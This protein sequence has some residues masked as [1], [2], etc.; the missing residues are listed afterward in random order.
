MAGNKILIVEDETAIARM[1]WGQRYRD[2]GETRTVDVHIGQLRKRLGLSEH[3]KTVQSWDIVW[4]NRT[5]KIRTRIIWICCAAVLAS[6]L[7]GDAVLW[8][9]AGRSFQN[10]AFIEA[11]QNAYVFMEEFRQTL[12]EDEGF[13][14]S[15]VFLQYYFKT[16]G[17]DYNICI[18]S[19][20]DY[21]GKVSQPEEIYNQT[22]IEPES[23]L[24]LDYKSRENWNMVLSSGRE[25]GMADGIPAVGYAGSGLCGHLRDIG[26]SKEGVKAPAGAE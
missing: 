26:D 14:D 11:Y 10:E 22:V 3:I 21:G 20:S 4:R 18:R 8:V 17:D 1:I 23:L 5:L 7:L 24:K 9:L 25:D 16:R 6:S 19:S 15:T 13:S 2:C 12:E